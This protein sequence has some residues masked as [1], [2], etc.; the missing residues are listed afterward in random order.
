MTF[1]PS[2]PY[3][4]LPPLPPPIDCESKAILRKCISAHR[5]LAQ[6]KIAGNL[7]PNQ[8]ILIN[9]IPLQEA[10]ASSEIENIVTTGDALYRADLLS[11]KQADPHTKEVLHYRKA[12]YHGYKLLKEGHRI[13]V[14]FL[15]SICNDIIQTEVQIRMFGPG[16]IQNKTTGEIVYLAP[17]GEVLQEKLSQFENFI[18]EEQMI[19]PLICLALIHYQLEAIHP[20]EDGNGRTGRILN[21]LYLVNKELLEI[22]V[23]YLS[24]YIIRHKNDYYRLLRSVTENGT[25][26]DWIL[27]MLDAIEVTSIQTY[28]KILQIRDLLLKTT[29]MCRNELHSPI[30]SKEL[31]ELVFVQPYSKIQFIVDAKLAKRQTAAHYLNELERIGILNSKKIGRERIYINSALFRILSEG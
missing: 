13:T 23:L 12:L 20:F 6:L 5:A 30:Y 14:P 10:K 16:I 15:H 18:A 2:K 3:N 26:E 1:N 25:W 7:I 27:F 17:E 22:P 4:D 24:H 9:A 8:T 19:D 29:N 11:E 31:I 28:E 21:I